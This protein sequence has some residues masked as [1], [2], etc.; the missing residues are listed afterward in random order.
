[1]TVA[2]FLRE[3]NKSETSAME[4]QVQENCLYLHCAAPGTSCFVC[5]RYAFKFCGLD[6]THVMLVSHCD[7]VIIIKC[8]SKLWLHDTI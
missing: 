1:M 4:I 2:R 3:E 5:W 6:W 7:Q 8:K